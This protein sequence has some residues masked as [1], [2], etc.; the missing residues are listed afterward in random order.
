M[1]AGN[2]SQLPDLS[3][4]VVSEKELNPLLFDATDYADVSDLINGIEQIEEVTEIKLDEL[5]INGKVIQDDMDIYLST[6]AISSSA[7]KEALKTPLH[8]FHYINHS[9]PKKDKS[10]FELGT[11]CHMAFLEPELFDKCLIEPSHSLASN[12]GANALISFWESKVEPRISLL[13]KEIVKSTGADLDKIQ[14]KKQYYNELKIRSGFV[15]VDEE[16]KIIIDVIKSNYYRYGNGIIPKILKGAIFETSFYGVDPSTGLN[17]KVRPDAL[18]VSENIGVNAVIS[19]K[20][21]KAD[22]INKFQYDSAQYK[23]ELSEGMYLDVISDVTGR[24]FNAVI[25]IMLQ[26]C[27]PFLPAVL[28]W[29]AD[30]LANGKYKYHSALQ[31]IKDC[32]ESKVFPGFDALAENGNYGIISMK[33]PDWAMKELLPVSI[34]N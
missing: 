28:F 1:V 25:T 30:D 31:V 20:T 19:F 7:C 4:A 14:G 8:Y 33:Q 6:K 18:N 17:V 5:A 29:D 16:H 24:K 22:T 13:A 32:N 21:T 11:F 26:T 9:L 27:A 10:H 15:S 3:Q 23:Y 2:Q 34:E 12:D